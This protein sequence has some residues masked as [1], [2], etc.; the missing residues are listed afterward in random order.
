MSTEY[1]KLHH[2]P[3]GRA[4]GRFT[5]CELAWSVAAG[6]AAAIPALLRMLYP[7]ASGY[8]RARARATGHSFDDADRLALE[9]CRTVL[10]VLSSP[11]GAQRDFV[12]FTYST[13]VVAADRRFGAPTDTC[14]TRLQQE[15]LIL[16]TILGFD[17]GQTAVALGITPQRVLVEQHAALRLFR[18]A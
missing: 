3:A 5:M 12:R 14:M 13:A 15:T 17:A 16:R 8:C 2:I 9:V 7:P 10:G 4:G 18:A 11:A 6:D 1:R